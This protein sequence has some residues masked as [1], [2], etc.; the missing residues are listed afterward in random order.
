MS[1]VVESTANP[2]P[3]QDEEATGDS[4]EPDS[5]MQPLIE[6]GVQKALNEPAVRSGIEHVALEVYG[7]LTE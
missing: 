5:E 4:Q 2:L 7:K 3:S 1:M 6:K